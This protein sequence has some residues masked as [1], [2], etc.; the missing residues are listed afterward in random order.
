MARMSVGWCR[1]ICP[2]TKKVALI[3][4][5]QLVE[6][7]MCRRR[8]PLPITSLECRIEGQSRGR[9]DAEVLLD[10]EAQN[11]GRVRAVVRQGTRGGTGADLQEVRVG[12]LRMRT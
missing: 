7:P 9:L 4:P 11:G 10:I 3:P 5:I 1:A 2:N 8:Q 6:Q 12:V